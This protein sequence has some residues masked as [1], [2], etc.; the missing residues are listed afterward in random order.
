MITGIT[1]VRNE[2]LIIEDTLKHFLEFCE[3][4]ILYDDDSTDSTVEIASSFE[5]VQVIRGTSWNKDRPR[6]ETRQRRLLLDK[7][8]TPWTWCFDAD[9]RLVG[10][11]PDLDADAYRFRLFDGYMTPGCKKAYK[12]GYLL[13]LKRKWGP[14]FRD[15]LMLFKTDKA[16]YKGLDKREPRVKGRTARSGAYIKHFGKCISKAQWEE[17]CHYYSEFWPEPYRSKWKARRGKAIHTE[18]DFGR[19]L[20]SWWDLMTHK[21]DWVA[22]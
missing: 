16:I 12:K 3:S 17:T 13:D 21:N 11:L 22:I 4:V 19:A 5:R 14:E 8:T 1:K 6:E 18:S 2:A 20:Y 7:V 10:E 9:E 15:I